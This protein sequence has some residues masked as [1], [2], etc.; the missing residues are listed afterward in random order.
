MCRTLPSS[1]SRHSGKMPVA[2]PLFQRSS[3]QR[4]LSC[5]SMAS[6]CRPIFRYRRAS[7]AMSVGPVSWS[8]GLDVTAR[9][10]STDSGGHRPARLSGAGPRCRAPGLDGQ[11]FDGRLGRQQACSTMART[12]WQSSQPHVA[13][14]SPS[15]Q[16]RNSAWASSFP[17][18][19]TLD[20]GHAWPAATARTA[21]QCCRP[22]LVLDVRM[23]PLAGMAAHGSN[24]LARGVK[25]H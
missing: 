23:R 24:S 4:P 16:T 13:A 19:S 14:W 17:A 9:G 18:G 15:C 3:Y 20:T 1:L 2:M 22:S 8:P 10:T 7:G 11:Q 6:C 12:V 25:Y 21:R 5:P